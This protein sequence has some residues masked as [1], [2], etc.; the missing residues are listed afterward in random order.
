MTITNKN[1]NKQ[2]ENK[3]YC[4][5]NNNKN[6]K[7]KYAMVLK[8]LVADHFN[9]GT[10]TTPQEDT[11]PLKANLGFKYKNGLFYYKSFNNI[12]KPIEQETNKTTTSTGLKP[13]EEKRTQ[14][15]IILILHTNR[16]KNPFKRVYTK[17]FKN[18]YQRD[19]THI[20]S[21][22]KFRL[23]T[24]SLLGAV[25]NLISNKVIKGRRPLKA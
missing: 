14:T 11:T 10:Q 23:N 17:M 25:D 19:T 24:S 3:K 21:I 5:L 12:S 18:K 2:Q 16:E 15:K 6:N 20:I 7:N 8:G 4:G 1:N 13:T 9:E 22:S